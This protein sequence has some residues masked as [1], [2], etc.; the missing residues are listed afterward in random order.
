[1]PSNFWDEEKELD[2]IQ[3]NKKDFIKPVLA[4]KNGKKYVSLKAFYK[5]EKDNTFKPTKDAPFVVSLE[6]FNEIVAAI[7]KK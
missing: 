6:V 5:N 4:K 7:N 3:K 1:M 2:F